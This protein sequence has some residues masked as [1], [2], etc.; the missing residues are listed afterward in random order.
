[1]ERKLVLEFGIPVNEYL[2]ST[3]FEE[4]VHAMHEAG[5]MSC[6]RPYHF[7]GQRK[8]AARAAQ[9]WSHYFQR[10]RGRIL[11][12]ED[13]FH[14][15]DLDHRIAMPRPLVFFVQ[16]KGTVPVRRTGIWIRHHDLL[17]IWPHNLLAEKVRSS[18]PTLPIM[19]R[20]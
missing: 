3:R 2:S 11:N 1:M 7:D 4:R 13:D 6:P 15:R 5:L 8:P 12:H 16:S 18:D 9:G 10:W 20:P 17:P 19:A 14:S